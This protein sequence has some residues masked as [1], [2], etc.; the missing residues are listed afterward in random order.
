MSGGGGMGGGMMGG[1]ITASEIELE[2]QGLS[3]TVSSYSSTGSQA[4][5]TLSVANRAG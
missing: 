5:F 3:G 1:T 4:T 2:Q